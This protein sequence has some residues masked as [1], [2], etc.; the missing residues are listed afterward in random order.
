V[1]VDSVGWRPEADSLIHTEAKGLQV[2]IP[3]PNAQV[4]APSNGSSYRETGDSF[5]PNGGIA[6][7]V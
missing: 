1:A 4:M 7:S 2:Q 3:D 6:H 5:G